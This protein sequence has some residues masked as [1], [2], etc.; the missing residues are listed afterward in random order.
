MVPGLT[1]SSVL[2]VAHEHLASTLGSGDLDVLATPAL[3]ALAENAAMLAVKNSLP[4]G[5]T[6]V[7]GR[8]E[9]THAKPSALGTTVVATA[10]LTEIDGRKLTFSIEATDGADIVGSG[11]HVRF[12]V[13]SER[14]MAKLK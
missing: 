8:I 7:G 13:D 1:H 6:T 3:V 14:F 2:V 9:L 5:A 4:A 10:I 12:V 11:T